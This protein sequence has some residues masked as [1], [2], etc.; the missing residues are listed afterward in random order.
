MISNGTNPVES[1]LL[2]NISVP[3]KASSGQLRML[4]K[5]RRSIVEE[6][7]V[8]STSQCERD[9]SKKK[10]RIDSGSLLV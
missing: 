8:L 4:S 1:I 6:E 10:R 3:A 2:T 7:L 9:S 5:D